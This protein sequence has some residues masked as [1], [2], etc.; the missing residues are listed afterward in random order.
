M[1]TRYNQA[2]KEQPDPGQYGATELAT[3][4]DPVSS[5]TAAPPT[6]GQVPTA[7]S[8]TE[9]EWQT[10]IAGGYTTVED[11][12]TP[13]TQRSAMN[14]VGPGVTAADV[15]GK[16][17]VSIAGGVQLDVANTWTKKQT[18]TPDDANIAVEGTGGSS[19]S[20]GLKGT[21]GVTNGIGVEGI[22][23]G[24]GSGVEGTGGGSN[25][26]GVKGTGGTNGIGV[27]GVGTGAGIGVRAQSTTARAVY[28]TC[29]S[30]Y[31]AILGE[32]AGN[33]TGVIGAGGASL[34]IGV[35]GGS[36]GVPSPTADGQGVFGQGASNKVGVEGRGLAAGTGVKGRG[37]GSN[38]IGVIGGGDFADPAPTPASQGVYGLGGTTGNGTGVEG[39]GGGTTGIGVKGTGGASGNT[40]GVEGVAGGSIGYGVQG[41]GFHGVHGIGT[42]ASSIGVYGTGVRYGVK[43]STATGI[44]V[45]AEGD[46]TNPAYPA[47]RI[48]PQDDDPTD[49]AF[50]GLMVTDLDHPAQVQGLLR[51][52]A[53]NGWRYVGELQPSAV[54][55][56]T[57]TAKIGY[58][59]AYDPSGGTFTINAPATPS[60]GDHFSVK[61]VTTNTTVITISGN[62][63]NIED[64]VAGALVA[65]FTIGIGLVAVD[66]Q[67]INGAWHVI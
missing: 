21:G 67:F 48:V 60:S 26:V 40:P 45:E 46:F 27:Q 12:G 30:G 7:T 65:S 14:F 29:G 50:G 28:A 56:T 35:I 61:N 9:Y 53:Y 39:Q 44:G 47:L 37:G 24:T 1:T 6:A 49:V 17:Q 36:G 54:R 38:G 8:A 33:G 42:G 23:A 55:T 4:G 15:G 13:L 51:I 25:G 18:F 20:T 10:P 5:K 52:A 31:N 57:G 22:G 43:G 58:R 16:T 34:G 41:T 3:T 19:N 62:G 2:S 63:N 32:S 64:P 11:E 66:F 59:E